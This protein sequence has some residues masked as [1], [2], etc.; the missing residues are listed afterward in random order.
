MLYIFQ[1]HQK[2]RFFNKNINGGVQNRLQS[3]FFFILVYFLILLQYFQQENIF[4]LI[5]TQFQ[6]FIDQFLTNFKKKHRF[7]AK[8]LQDGVQKT[9]SIFLNFFYKPNLLTAFCIENQI[10]KPV[11]LLTVSIFL[12]QVKS[13]KHH[14]GVQTP[15]SFANLSRID[16]LRPGFPYTLF[17]L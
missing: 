13:K 16:F 3:P 14:K 1:K 9:F 6:W 11:T 4:G 10:L 12:K 7:F 17:F 15:A 8:I 5:S 2:S